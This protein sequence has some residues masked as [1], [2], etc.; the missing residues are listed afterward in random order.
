M[1][2]NKK[3]FTM[4][5]LVK[6]L[7][8]VLVFIIIGFVIFVK[9]NP[10]GTQVGSIIDELG[11]CDRDRVANMFDKCPC[12]TTGGEEETSL[13]GCPKGTTPAQSEENIRTCSQFVDAVTGESLGKMICPDGMV[14]STRCDYIEGTVVVVEEV[15]EAKGVPTNGNLK[16]T[17]LKI[18][19]ESKPS[20]S[21]DLQQ[22]KYQQVLVSLK[23]INDGIEEINYPFYIRF[24]TC[25]IDDDSYCF[26]KKFVLN[27]IEADFLQITRST[28]VD[29]EYSTDDLI[30]YLGKDGD[31]CDTSNKCSL[32]AIIDSGADIGEQI[33]TDN[34]IKTYIYLTN[35]VDQEFSFD[36]VW[37]IELVIDDYGT[38]NPEEK[39]IEQTCSVGD[40]EDGYIGDDGEYPYQCPSAGTSCGK[41]EFPNKED[42]FPEEKGCLFV[43]TNFAG[44]N[45]CGFG[46]AEDGFI[47]DIIDPHKFSSL[48]S[49]FKNTDGD[50]AGSALEY[51]WTAKDNEGS[52]ICKEGYWEVCNE[53]AEGQFLYLKEKVFRCIG[54]R[55]VLRKQ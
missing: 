8:P 19:A 18:N 39:E 46:G 23:Y 11:D 7:I 31:V 51:L 6:I 1:M 20:H 3:G 29:K 27:G 38:P 10:L 2:I 12:L 28:Q 52:L 36:K 45:D 21:F 35:Q 26:N 25:S 22:G 24:R 42:T 53:E 34:E 37:T 4:E 32:K 40:K 55:W 9:Y 33:E 47:L 17:E 14:C 43:V 48:K 30:M 5:E 15:E 49:S 44:N 16:I 50:K 54:K 41:D 13:R